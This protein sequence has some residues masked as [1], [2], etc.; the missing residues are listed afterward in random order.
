MRH[1]QPEC[2]LLVLSGQTD[3][4]GLIQL[5]NE[6][7][8]YRFLPKPWHDYFLKSSLGQAISYVSELREN[9]RLAQQIRE[10]GIA[11]PA[12]LQEESQHIL[13]VD[14]EPAVLSSLSRALGRHELSDELY[15]AIQTEVLHEPEI[16]LAAGRLFVHTCS[17]PHQALLMAREMSF[18]CIVADYRMA[19]MNGVELLSRMAEEQPDCVRLLISGQINQEELINAVDLAHIFG[20]IGKPWQDFE[21][22]GC[23][24]QALAWRRVQLDNRTLAG[25]VRAVGIH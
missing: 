18:A 1:Q 19:E 23:I 8:I 4:P 6:A 11:V 5:I 9:R 13:I 3:M 10:H 17:S 7:H 16:A 25:M 14:D 15:T 2:A 20:F 21:L 24:A 12:G 22:K